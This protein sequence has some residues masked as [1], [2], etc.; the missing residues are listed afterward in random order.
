M[1]MAKHQI[2]NPIL[3]GFYP[4][5]SICRAGD[6][7]Y[8][9][10]SSF[11]MTP[12]IPVFYS[13]DLAHWTQIG[14]ALSDEN[15]SHIER[16]AGVGGIMAP[17]IRYNNG[18]FYIIDTNLADQG[19]FILTA[20]DH[21]GPWSEPHWMTDVP[22][23]D[24]S[25][26]FDDGKSYIVGIGNVIDLGDGK[27]DRGFWIAEYDLEHFQRLCDPVVIFDSALRRAWSP[28]SPHIY[29]VGD[30]YYLVFAEGGTDHYHTVMCARSKD[31]FGFYEGCEANPL[32]THRHMGLDAPIINVGHA[33]LVQ[34]PDGSWYAVFLASRLIDGR[35][36]NLGRETW[37]CPVVWQDDGWPYFTPETGKVEWTYDAPESLP[38][39]DEVSGDRFYD[40]DDE[41]LP[42]D[43][44]FWGTQSGEIPAM[45]GYYA[46]EN[47]QRL[48]RA[49]QLADQYGVSVAQ[50][51]IAW[52]FGQELQVIPL[53]GGENA[54]MYAQTL[55]A[56]RMVLSLDEIKWLN[57]EEK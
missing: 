33:D 25:L 6:D 48:A 17:T 35:H 4:D 22:D 38:W 34:I 7:F 27:K 43:M 20:K 40:F 31:L 12:G 29:H 9:V 41:K 1:D 53:Q 42:I 37:L 3:P 30:Y 16:D 15:H 8:L 44:T 55:E 19:N 21:A 54:L 57:L 45:K 5:P 56:S 24:A 47:F 49:E 14:N 39:Q 23:I 11:E 36:K 26:F 10:C 50:I 46:D 32:L 2:K 13:K 51:A 28:E 18:T 52:L